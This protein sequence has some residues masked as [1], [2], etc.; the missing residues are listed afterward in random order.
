M[1]GG[2]QE[3]QTIPSSVLD[4]VLR[5]WDLSVNIS[6]DPHLEETW[7][8]QKAYTA[9]KDAVDGIIDLLQK[10][11]LAQPLPQSIWHL[12]VLDQY[13]DFSSQQLNQFTC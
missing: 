11:S 2:V 3:L 4:A 13:V 12:I 1:L 9:G 6:K 7:R 5:L 10:Q 8:F